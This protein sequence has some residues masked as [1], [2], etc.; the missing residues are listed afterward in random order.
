MNYWPL[1]GVLVVV[2]GFV[3]RLNPIAVV[4]TAGLASGLAAGKPLLDLLALI[5]ESFL[6]QRALSL[7]FLTLPVIGV[8]EWAGLREQARRWITGFRGLTF[9]RLMVS[10]L[11]LRQLLSM[12]G[13]TNVAGHAQTVRPL[14]A[15]MA[16]A[17]VEKSVGAIAPAQRQRV[18]GLA[19]AT[20][21]VGLFFGEDVFLAFGGVLL[22]QG[23]LAEN[24]HVFEPL[25][26]ALWALPTA[27][28]AFA[29]HATRL[30]LFQRRLVAIAP[31]AQE[32]DRAAH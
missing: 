27:I 1:L 32:A 10:Y 25:Q 13:L 17:A 16:E 5:G 18:L 12:I 4:V 6:S 19:A 30:W 8:L 15:P 29:I 21:N 2:I 26:I 28:A 9:A 22:I 14:L 20:D 3:L 23:F 11:G 31:P 24:G 7:V